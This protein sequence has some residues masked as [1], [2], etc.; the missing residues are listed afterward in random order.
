MEHERALEWLVRAE[1][2]SVL[3]CELREAEG[4]EMMSAVDA[5]KKTAKAESP[6]EVKAKTKVV[7]RGWCLLTRRG[8]I[9]TWADG[10]IGSG[11]PCVFTS[12]QEAE[13]YAMEGEE[14]GERAVR[15]RVE[16]E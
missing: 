11:S 4:G 10:G 8:K 13:E 6:K 12:R 14:T 1:R 9:C 15:I 7:W 2:A 16:L 3:D 5:A